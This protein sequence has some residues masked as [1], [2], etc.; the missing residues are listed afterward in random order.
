MAAAESER[1]SD[2]EVSAGPDAKE[3]RVGGLEYHRTGVAAEVGPGKMSLPGATKG[4][5][6]KTASGRKNLQ[7]DA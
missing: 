2:A 5:H 6:E 7:S 1:T 3:K 4:A